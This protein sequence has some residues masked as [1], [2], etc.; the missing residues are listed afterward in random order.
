[1]RPLA[2]RS[3][4]MTGQSHTCALRR[5][6]G[7]ASVELLGV[8]PLVILVG[9]VVWQI[10]LA[11]HAVWLCANAARVAARA[12]LVGREAEAAARSALPRGLE[13]GLE[14]RSDRAGAVRVTLRV[15]LLIH[16]W[17][18]PISVSATASLEGQ[19]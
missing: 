9:L 13:K 18:G 5:Q 14:V 12:E 17:Q 16:R 19:P 2:G 3:P 6:R 1:M 15:P 10:A 4:A 8:L 11:G 7:Q